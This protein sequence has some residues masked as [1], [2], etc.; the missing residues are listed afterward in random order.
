[1]NP[2]KALGQNAAV[3]KSP[4]FPLH[5]AGDRALPFILPPKPC[6]K[7]SGD[8]A[9]KGI[10]FG[11]AGTVFGGCFADTGTFILCIECEGTH[12]GNG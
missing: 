10:V 3:E 4:E 9:V 1:M 11:I 6:F 5:E 8:D 12:D 7:M 2:K